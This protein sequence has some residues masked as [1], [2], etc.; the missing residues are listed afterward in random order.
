MK[1]LI[2]TVWIAGSLCLDILAAPTPMLSI[3]V[4]GRVLDQHERPIE[5]ATVLLLDLDSTFISG[6]TTST[7]GSF[8]LTSTLDRALLCVTSLGFLDT[9]LLLSGNV[10]ETLIIKLREESHTLAEISVTAKKPLLEQREDRLVMNLSGSSSAAGNSALQILSRAPGIAIDQQSSAV[11]L[12]GKNGAQIMINGR[13]SRAPLD[14][15]LNQLE[16][17]SAENIESIEIIHQPPA[18]YSA[19]GAGLINIVFKKD[20]SLGFNASL[21]ATIGYGQKEKWGMGGSFNYHTGKSNVYGDANYF[22]DL[23]D[24]YNFWVGREYDYQGSIYEHYNETVLAFQRKRS[25]NARL[26]TDIDLADK[27]TLG[28]LGGMGSFRHN[29]ISEGTSYDVIDH[30]QNPSYEYEMRPFVLNDHKYIN[31]NLF[32]QME[33]SSLNFDADYVDYL[34]SSPGLFF[35]K[36]GFGEDL[37]TEI[38]VDRNTP[39]KIGTAKADF[40]KHFQGEHKLELGAKIT[41]STIDNRV[42][43][44]SKID[45]MWKS[46]NVFSNNDKIEESI[47]AAYISF[48]PKVTTKFKIESGIRYEYIDYLID[49]ESKDRNQHRKNGSLFPVV[50]LNYKIDSLNSLQISYNR[51]ITRP[52][53]NQLASHFVFIDPSIVSTGNP[54]LR[55]AFTNAVKLTYQ[56]RSIYFSLEGNRNSNYIFYYNTVDKASDFQTSITHNFTRYDIASATLSFPIHPVHWSD[57]TITAIGQYREIEDRNR[58]VPFSTNRTNLILQYNQVFRLGKSW[59]ADFNAMRL[60]NVSMVI[61]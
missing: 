18:K 50:R 45:D 49:S 59:S 40:V 31:L 47:Y 60:K 55:P 30:I 32:H 56:R 43:I 58:T 17:M 54:L 8:E 57:I 5:F 4:D 51:R 36:K 42:S 29:A 37:P 1:Q 22:L 21:N 9:T 23:S 20:E 44:R 3:T 28:V 38:E 15:V 52:R 46:D 26:G 35:L 19:S 12:N 25:Y 16:S 27:T 53:Y 39:L 24:K 6:T 14:V 7:E 11:S 41:R 13:L 48:V 2:L 10:S 61:K 34:L 33:G